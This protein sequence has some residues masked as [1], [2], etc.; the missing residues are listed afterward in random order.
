M[1]TDKCMIYE[2]LKCLSMH[3]DR[4]TVTY[5]TIKCVVIVTI[6]LYFVIY[7]KD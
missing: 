5:S 7:V 2:T 3:N 6:F 4:T 1:L